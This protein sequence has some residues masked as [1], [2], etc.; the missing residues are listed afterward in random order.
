MFPPGWIDLSLQLQFW[1]A[2]DYYVI[3]NQWSLGNVYVEEKSQSQVVLM[4]AHSLQRKENVGTI[5]RKVVK[6]H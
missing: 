1:D 6:E 3:K 4:K 5:D 2:A